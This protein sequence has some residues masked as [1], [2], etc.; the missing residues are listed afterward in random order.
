MKSFSMLSVLA[1]SSAAVAAV[2]KAEN[3]TM[4]QSGSSEVTITYALTAAPVV[5]TLMTALSLIV[6]TPSILMPLGDD[7]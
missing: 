4:T 6:M 5:V 3:V 2:P 7:L 1:L